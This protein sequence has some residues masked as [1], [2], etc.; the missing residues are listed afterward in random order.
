MTERGII[1]SAGFL[2]RIAV[3]AQYVSKQTLLSK[4]S[5]TII[6]NFQDSHAEHKLN[7]KKQLI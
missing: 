7:T 1:V 4:H 5:N 2:T 3:T 6:S